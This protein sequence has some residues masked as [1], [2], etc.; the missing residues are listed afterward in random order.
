MNVFHKLAMLSC[1][2]VSLA[3][4][5][6]SPIDPRIEGVWKL[7]SEKIERGS[8]ASLPVGSVMTVTRAGDH[9]II[10]I[11]EGG[12][13]V[14]SAMSGGGPVELEYDFSPDAKTMTQTVNGTDSHT[15]KPYSVNRVWQ[16]QGTSRNR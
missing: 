5:S 14:P 1:A 8:V 10:G 3:A 13:V 9:V 16:R 6:I 15:G 12:K 2:V 7:S 11:T 4:Q